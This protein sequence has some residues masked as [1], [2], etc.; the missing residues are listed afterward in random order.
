V[1][2]VIL[3]FIF[4]VQHMQNALVYDDIILTNLI[5]NFRDFLF[6]YINDG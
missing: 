4:V 3:R 2:F 6:A 5:I 1:I